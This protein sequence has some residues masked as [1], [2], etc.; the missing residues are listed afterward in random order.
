MMIWRDKDALS[1]IGMRTLGI[2]RRE[3]VEADLC[4]LTRRDNPK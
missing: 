3:I 1:N 2:P 4:L